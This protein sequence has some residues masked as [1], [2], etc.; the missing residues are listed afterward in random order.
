MGL[1]RM[2]PEF[3]FGSGSCVFPSTCPFLLCGIHYLHFAIILFFCTS[4]LVL[5]VSCCSRPIEDKHVSDSHAVCVTNIK[6]T[7]FTCA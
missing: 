7:A 3:W 1:C 5:V 4:V 2:L 6:T